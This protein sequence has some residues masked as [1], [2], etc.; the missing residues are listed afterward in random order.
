M[1]FFITS[2]ST[3]KALKEETEE[4]KKLSENEKGSITLLHPDLDE[5]KEPPAESAGTFHK[6]Y[7]SYL[8][9]LH[10][11]EV[12]IGT[13]PGTE[14]TATELGETLECRLI[15]MTSIKI[16]HRLFSKIVDQVD[17]LWSTDTDIYSHNE[18][19]I[20]DIY[21]TFGQKHKAILP[22]LVPNLV[23]SCTVR[24]RQLSLDSSTTRSLISLKTEYEQ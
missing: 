2:I 18:T 6:Q 5:Q 20:R 15:L 12:V 23:T 7:F 14:Q 11:I 17:E 21:P 4:A 9:N 22:H 19:I 24:E 16:D 3:G 8:S 10:D 13:L 1:I